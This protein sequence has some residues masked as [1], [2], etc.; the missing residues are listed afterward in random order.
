MKLFE[1][2]RCHVAAALL[3]V[4]VW[5]TPVQAA[6]VTVD[7]LITITEGTDPNDGS[8]AAGT[9]FNGSLSYDDSDLTPGDAFERTVDMGALTLLFPFIPFG[10]SAFIN[11]ITELDPTVFGLFAL[12]EG[13]GSLKSL[14]FSYDIGNDFF[15]SVGGGNGLLGG[16]YDFSRLELVDDGFGGFVEEQVTIASGKIALSVAEVPLPATMPLLLAAL[17]GGAAVARRRAARL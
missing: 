17:M 15:L 9:V 14:D 11:P 5:A 1:A 7:F 3:V 8:D 4:P 16:A 13:D 6:T 12:F 10:G 2:F